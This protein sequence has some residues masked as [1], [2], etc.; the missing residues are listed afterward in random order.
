V[1]VFLLPIGATEE[2]NGTTW[3]TSPG[4]MNTARRSAAGAGTS[5]S[6]IGFGGYGATY[7]AFTAT[8][9]YDGTSWATSPG[10]LATGRSYLSSAGTVSLAVAMG[11]YTG[12]GSD[13][14]EEWTGAGA[15]LTVTITAS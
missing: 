4:S 1:V 13:A 9:E 3:A 8:E 14:T 11:G 12:S 2:Y 5:S 10:S 6:A 7:P 15:P